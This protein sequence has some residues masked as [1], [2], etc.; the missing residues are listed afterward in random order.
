MTYVIFFQQ[1]DRFILVF[2]KIKKQLVVSSQKFTVPRDVGLIGNITNASSQYQV[3][4]LS[5]ALLCLQLCLL[6]PQ[7]QTLNSG[8]H[9]FTCAGALSYTPQSTMHSQAVSH[10]CML[11]VLVFIHN[12]FY[13]QCLPIFS[14]SFSIP[15]SPG[16]WPFFFLFFKALIISSYRKSSV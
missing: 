15:K 14:F 8:S 10:I 6:L 2:L 7:C 9:M 12:S 4:W 11:L 13:F 1:C 5:F 3:L 16:K